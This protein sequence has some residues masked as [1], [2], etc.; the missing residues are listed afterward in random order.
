MTTH[1]I[2]NR[3]A[4]PLLIGMLTGVSAP[5]YG[6]TQ[7]AESAATQPPIEQ[8]L[9]HSNDE[10]EQLLK[11]HQLYVSLA[12]HN[13]QV[14]VQVIIAVEDTLPP[15]LSKQ[16]IEQPIPSNL[17]QAIERTANQ[18]ADLTTVLT[19]PKTAKCSALS[20][21]VTSDLLPS[22]APDDMALIDHVLDNQPDTSDTT[23]D[24][25][26]MYQLK[27]E[28]IESL[29]QLTITAFG[30]FPALQSAFVEWLHEDQEGHAFVKQGKPTVTLTH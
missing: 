15:S 3:L 16:P 20:S 25:Q 22:E 12:Q 30:A 26:A 7:P 6:D 9:M 13:K 27:C 1:P 18:L 19:I 14:M 29:T 23:H 4:L 10:S 5:T 28:N 2:A 8:P 17:T 21:E 24:F 11:P